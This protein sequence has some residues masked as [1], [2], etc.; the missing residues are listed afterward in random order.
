[1]PNKAGMPI[2][3]L[4]ADDNQVMRNAIRKLLVEEPLIKIVGEASTF[5]ETAQAVAAAKPD[6]LLLDLR[7]PDTHELPAAVRSQL[8]C[9]D[10]T[11]AVSFAIDD[12][13]QSL[14]ASYG[15]VTLLD[16]MTLYN[17][18][19][20][21]ILRLADASTQQQPFTPK[22]QGGREGRSAGLSE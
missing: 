7:M 12:E 15:T 4:I 9:V 6:V 17:T 11:I 5:Q 22:F 19:V 21:A 1:M 10:H 2:K 18:L 8:Q 14:A 13:A 3:I 16:K 20:P